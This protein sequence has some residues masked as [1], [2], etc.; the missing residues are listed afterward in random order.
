MRI[1]PLVEPYD[2]RTAA[3]LRSMMPA[4]VAPIGLFRTFA[5]N[6]A[7]AEAMHQ[8]Q[9]SYLLSRR[10]TVD[11]R[12]R[13]IVI[14]RVCARCGSEYEFGVHAAYFAQRVGLTDDQLRS[15]VWG[16]SDDACWTDAR[17]SAVIRFVDAL[18]DTNDV[19]DELWTELTTSF[20]ERQ[21]LDLLVLAGWYHAISFVARAARVPLEDW[22]PT[23][24]SVR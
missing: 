2:E 7:L 14:D 23:F 4:G 22:A 8:G 16:G 12:I 19:G 1:V 9:G 20:T 24:M 11:M 6:Y 15:L 18:H 17:E 10:L 21:L 3:L 13:E 5:K